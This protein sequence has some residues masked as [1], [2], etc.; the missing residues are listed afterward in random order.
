MAETLSHHLKDFFHA[1]VPTDCTPWK[2]GWKRDR[3]LCGDLFEVNLVILLSI[4]LLVT[5]L[6]T[7]IKAS[8]LNQCTAMILS[9]PSLSSPRWRS[10]I[11]VVTWSGFISSNAII[12]LHCGDNKTSIISIYSI[13]DRSRSPLYPH[14]LISRPV[15]ANN[16][17]FSLRWRYVSY[18]VI[19]HRLDIIW[20]YF[21]KT[22][23]V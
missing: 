15:I 12:S 18:T 20:M 1:H 17:H 8:S 2:A 16:K 4:F 11:V 14:S 3:Q 6:S 21:W 5:R 13:P 19:C 7:K 10:L 23:R 9:K 22:T